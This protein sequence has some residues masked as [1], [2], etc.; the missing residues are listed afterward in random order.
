MDEYRLL[1]EANDTK[2]LVYNISKI[3]FEYNLNIESNSE[4]VDNETNNFFMRTVISGEVNC[5]KLIDDI[6]LTFRD[7]FTIKLFF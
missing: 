5:E 2:G 1:I 3:L 7:Y 6:K 4:Y